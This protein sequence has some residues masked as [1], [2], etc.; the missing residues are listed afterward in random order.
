MPKISTKALAT[1]YRP[2]TFESLCEQ[3]SIVAILQNQINTGNIAQAQL[4]VGPAG[5][6]K[7]TSARCFARMINENKGNPIEMDCASNNSVESIRDLC[8]KAQQKAIDCKYK[9][10]ILDEVHAL[11][12]ASWQAMLKIIEEPPVNTVFLLCTTDPQKIPATIL[13]RVQRFNFQ[14]I[15]NDGIYNRL[16][17]IIEEENK[18][19]ANLTYTKDALDF[20]TKLAAGGMRDA[21]SKLDKVVSYSDNITVE[22]VI[23]ALGVVDHSRLFDVVNY[24]VDQKE[25]ELITVIENVYNSGADL[26]LFIKQLNL[27]LLDCCKYN[28]F[29]TFDYIQIPKTYVQDLQNLCESVDIN[30]MSKMLNDINDLCNA[31]KWENSDIKSVVELKLLLMCRE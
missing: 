25:A 1:V 12:S 30:F 10:F 21:I 8:I 18:L 16:V 5:C 22:N 17:Y 13:S 27:F 11:S 9:V 6:G 24:I 23:V 4:F 29:K 20:I 14:R 19:G 26:K 2:K 3:K 31:I 28:I 15:S 7:T